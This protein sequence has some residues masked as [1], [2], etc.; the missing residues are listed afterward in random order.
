MLAIWHSDHRARGPEF[1]YAAVVEMLRSGDF[2][3]IPGYSETDRELLVECLTEFVEDV[4][5]ERP[6][7]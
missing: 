2:T 1:T 3:R 6:D 4:D 5:G 7:D